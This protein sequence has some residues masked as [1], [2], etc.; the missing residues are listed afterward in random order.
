MAM[1][2][3]RRDGR[4]GEGI[5]M[6]EVTTERRTGS[7]HWVIQPDWVIQPADGPVSLG[8]CKFCRETREFRNYIDIW[9]WNPGYRQPTPL[10]AEAEEDE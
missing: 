3:L 4:I 10:V 5:T 8:V 2:K 6:S 9:E 1:Q 7:H